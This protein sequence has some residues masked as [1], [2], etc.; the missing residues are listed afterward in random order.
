MLYLDMVGLQYDCLINPLGAV[1]STFE[2][3]VPT[4]ADPTSFDGKDWGVSD[5]FRE[6][7]FQNEAVSQNEGTWN[8]NKF[9]DISQFPMGHS[10]IFTVSQLHSIRVLFKQSLI[11][12]ETVK[13][14]A[15]T[16]RSL[17]QNGN[18]QWTENLSVYIWVP[19]DDAS[20]RHGQSLHKLLISYGSGRSGILGEVAVNLSSHLSSETS[21]TVAEPLKN[22]SYGTILQ[23]SHYKML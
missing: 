14:I 21:T 13:A 11:S 19:H 15:K 17:I 7:L 5:L 10:Q 3:A 9:T 12:V 22:C 20:K 23:V 2:K 1:R 8:S 6:Y 18:C 16:S 4:G